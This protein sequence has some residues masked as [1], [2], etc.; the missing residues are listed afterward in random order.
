MIEG[1]VKYEGKYGRVDRGGKVRR[2]MAEGVDRRSKARREMA[3]GFIDGVKYEG[4]W[5][6]G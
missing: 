5:L 3:E 4:K 1:G 2:E 6:R